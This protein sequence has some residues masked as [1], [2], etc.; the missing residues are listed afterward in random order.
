MKKINN[1]TPE[2]YLSTYD[3]SQTLYPVDAKDIGIK[4]ICVAVLFGGTLIKISSKDKCECNFKEAIENHFEDLMS[5]VFWQII[6]LVKDEVK[7]ALNILGHERLGFILTNAEFNSNLAWFYNGYSG[8][9]LNPPSLKSSI[10]H[11]VPILTVPLVV[12][13]F[14]K[15]NLSHKS[16]FWNFSN[17]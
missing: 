13:T 9:I 7:D 8:S 10:I 15:F 17:D 12:Q 14:S 2:V 11:S 3:D 16:L 1:L 6:G 4:N 5:P